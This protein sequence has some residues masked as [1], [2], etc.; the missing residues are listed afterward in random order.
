MASKHWKNT[1][2]DEGENIRNL[3]LLIKRVIM[4]NTSGFNEIA[5]SCP[6]AGSIKSYYLGWQLGNII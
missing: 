1:P 2:A 6:V 4:W 5:I 3:K